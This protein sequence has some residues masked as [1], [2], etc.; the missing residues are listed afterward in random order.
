MKF[1]E[2]PVAEAEGAIL[3]HSLRLGGTAL[4]KGRVLSAADLAALSTAG[5]EQVIAARLAP[6]DISEDMAAERIAAAAAGP[7]ITTATAFTGRANLFAATRGLLVFDPERL[8]DLNL[9]DEAVTLGTLP[10]FAVV[11]PRQMVA[12]VKIIPFA[13]PEAA[14]AK[15]AAFAAEGEP[16]LR[17]A[18]FVPRDVALIQ[19]R[20]PGFKESILDKTRA[21]TEQRL[22]ALGC[23]LVSEERCEHTVADLAPHI[24]AAAKTGADLVFVHGASVIVDRRDVIPEAVVAAGGH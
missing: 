19:T 16:L 8:D 5:T 20:L 1:G 2:V 23:R 12:T 11:D 22:S 14:V 9:V 24:A 10:P 15:A 7:N 18:A 21:V 6:G 17:V 13:V 4:K 3:A